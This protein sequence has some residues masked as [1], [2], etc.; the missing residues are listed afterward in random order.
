MSE[1]PKTNFASTSTTN[2]S[3]ICFTRQLLFTIF[4]K[5]RQKSFIIWFQI[6]SKLFGSGHKLHFKKTIFTDFGPSAKIGKI[7]FFK[8]NLWPLTN[9]FDSI[10]YHIM[11]DF[12]L[13]FMKIIIKSCLVQQMT[14]KFA[15]EVDS[16]IRFGKKCTNLQVSLFHEEI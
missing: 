11:K 12:E 5:F 3:V 15:V 10:W 1:F 9:K 14:E 7:V 4:I 13:N 16:K 2:F 6:G 8:Y